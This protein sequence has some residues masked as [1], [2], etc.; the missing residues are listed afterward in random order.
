MKATAEGSGGGFGDTR[1][2][3]ERWCH[4]FNR[5]LRLFESTTTRINA[6][7][8]I[9]LTAGN[10]A[11][12]PNPRCWLESSTVAYADVNTFIGTNGHKLYVNLHQTVVND[13]RAISRYE[14]DVDSKF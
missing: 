1:A 3:L 10:I 14:C 11:E 8:E 6:G 13:W 5:K 7:I 12:Y 4:T 2:M 9:D